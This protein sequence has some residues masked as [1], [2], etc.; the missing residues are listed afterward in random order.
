MVPVFPLFFAIYLSGRI[1]SAVVHPILVAVALWAF[2]HLLA[3]GNLADLLLFWSFLIWALADL[4]SLKYRPAPPV[5]G[6]PPGKF[7]DLIAIVAGLGLYCVFLFW[8][9]AWLIGVS[10]L[11]GD[12]L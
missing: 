8:A 4:I 12:A 10:P 11:G 1:Q 3:N 9:H 2:A 6:A 5:Q 7:N